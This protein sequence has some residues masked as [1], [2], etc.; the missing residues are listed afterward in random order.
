LPSLRQ[1]QAIYLEVG[2][3]GQGPDIVRQALEHIAELE[4]QQQERGE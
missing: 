2:A 3:G 1:A 4:R